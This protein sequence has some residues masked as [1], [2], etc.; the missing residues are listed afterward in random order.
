MSKERI[1]PPHFAGSLSGLFEGKYLYII[2]SFVM[3]PPSV[4]PSP[5]PAQTLSKKTNEH[6]FNSRS[7]S[8]NRCDKATRPKTG[9][10]NKRVSAESGAPPPLATR[11]PSQNPQGPVGGCTRSPPPPYYRN[12]ANFPP[13]DHGFAGV[14]ATLRGHEG[15]VCMKGHY[16]AH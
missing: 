15:R 2:S 12:D 14:P 4:R 10:V 8:K 3:S 6:L 16:L 11:Q 13:P 9:V 7:T 1:I 5:A